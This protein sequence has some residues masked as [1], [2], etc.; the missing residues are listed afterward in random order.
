MDNW[1]P[2][3][4]EVVIPVPGENT[5]RA[6]GAT[7]P[8]KLP[9]KLVKLHWNEDYPVTWFIRMQTISKKLWLCSENWTVND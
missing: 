4:L 7:A 5:G 8:G 1:C 9:R 2:P 6:P 3:T